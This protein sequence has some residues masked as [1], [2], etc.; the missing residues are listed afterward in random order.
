MQ[1]WTLANPNAGSGTYVLSSW[2]FLR[3]IGLIYVAAFVSI[4]AQIKGLVGSKGILPARDFLL[5]N[6]GRGPTRF[7]RMPTLCWWNAS[8]G[9]LQFLCWSGAA[10]S[11]LLVAGVAPI[12]VLIL[13]WAFYLSLFN[14]CRIF[15]GY[16]WDILLLETGFLAAFIAPFELFP[17]FPPATAPPRISLWLLWWLLFRLMF[18]SGFAKL[19]SGDGTWRNLT[20]L[21]H[22]YETQPLPTWTA[23]YVH[24]WPRWFHKLSVV[25]L[26]AIELVSPVLVFAPSPFSYVAGAAFVLLMLLIMS[27]GNYCFFN[28]LAIALSVLLFDDAVWLTLFGRFL[29]GVGFP[30]TGPLSRGW[31]AWTIVPVALVVALLSAQVICRLLR[32]SARWPKPLERLIEW[33]E[34]FRLVNGYGLFSVMTTGRREI[35]V[36]GSNDGLDWRV[37]EFK[38]KPGD[39]N[40][41]PRFVAPHQPRLDW[42]M[43]FAA[44]SHYQSTVWFRSFL[45]R[46]LQGSPEVLALLEK[47]PFSDKPPRLI[48]AVFY[49]YRFADFAGRRA[50][51]A[52]WRRERRG[53][54]SPVLSLRDGVGADGRSSGE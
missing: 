47:N 14:V 1:L 8:D 42:Q 45:M 29:T 53:S 54:Y 50:T 51:G 13:L 36:E 37:Y 32:S 21:N 9:F 40:R 11:L 15:F 2:L 12:P 26:F 4:G 5:A 19:R 46:L 6:Q 44:L 24:Q 39:V 35:I 34:P 18:S 16:Q 33:L 38:W 49:D 28:L 52:W 30:A 25:V 48:R 22:H 43:W 41:R 17:R 23:W 31:P 7:L 27:T 3:L 10:L 20:A